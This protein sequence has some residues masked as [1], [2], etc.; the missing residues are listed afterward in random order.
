MR[1]SH[2]Y[3]VMT[4]LVL[5]VQMSQAQVQEWPMVNI[6][7]ERTSWASGETQLSV[8]LEKTGVIPCRHETSSMSDISCYQGLLCISNSSNP[9]AVE[10]NSTESLDTLWTFMLTESGS[11]MGFLCAQ[12]DDFVFAGAQNSTQL[13]AL[14]RTSGEVV[15]QKTVGSLYTRHVIV[16]GDR[17]FLCSDSLFC[18]NTA[19]GTTVWN[20]SLKAQGTPAVDDTHV[21]IVG[22]LKIRIYDKLSGELVWMGPNSQ[23]SSGGICLDASC[24]YTFSNDTVFAFNKSDH[25]TK[26]F[27]V[28]SGATL[29]SRSQNTFAITDQVL[30]FIVRMNPE[31][32]G[33]LVTLDIK[34]GNLL[35][36]KTFTGEHMNSPVIV[37]GLVFV[38]PYAEQKLYGFNL[39]SGEEV[40][41]DNTVR[42]TGQP[43]ISAHKMY[44]MAR[45]EV[46][47]LETA[48]QTGV[49]EMPCTAPAGFALHQN[50]PNPFNPATE[51]RY[52]LSEPGQITLTLFNGLGQQI[53]MPVNGFRPAGRYTIR[54]DAA[55]LPAGTYFYRIAQG[56]RVQVRKMILMK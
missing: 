15:W 1:R 19:D 38:I 50:Y 17:L 56:E 41:S 20:S 29:Q 25:S 49:P 26:W 31:G 3:A 23:N 2:F 24:F 30:C 37:N 48:A 21:Y 13:Y 40:Y 22:K 36:E 14:D 46:M 42:Y 18:L 8:P 32:N 33:Q 43:L 51:I 47:V 7:R 45:N 35:W 16:D 44:V 10:A 53:A 54:F 39:M 9:N 12:T 55:H 5:L 4:A 27:Y 28:Q 11:S 34:N 52:E 6:C